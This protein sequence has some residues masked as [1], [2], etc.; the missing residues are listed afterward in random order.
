MVRTRGLEPPSLTA[1]PPQDCVSTSFTT[2]AKQDFIIASNLLKENAEH[3][4]V[5]AL[6]KFADQSFT[7]C[8]LSGKE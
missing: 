5:T 3:Y 2:P 8:S 6:A 7:F 1:Q 4:V